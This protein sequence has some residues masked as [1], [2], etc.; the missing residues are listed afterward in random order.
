MKKFLISSACA[1]TLA[2]APM[3][4][5][6]GEAQANHEFW[7]A[8]GAGVAGAV[9]VGI[10]ANAVAAGQ[11]HC[12]DGLGCHSHGGA[13]AYHFHDRYG[14]IV[15][16]QPVR[17]RVIQQPVEVYEDDPYVEP[18]VRPGRLPRAHYDWCYSRY[19]SYDAGSNTYQPLNAGGRRQC[20]S[21]YAG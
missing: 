1:A 2:V 9:A 15:Y 21:P 11:Q 7:H 5:S 17:Q 6:T 8:F 10:I 16:G 20:R 19:K 12:H 14:N 13:R 4:L 3:A 18:V